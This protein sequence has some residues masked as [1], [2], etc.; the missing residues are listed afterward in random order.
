MLV[1]QRSTFQQHDHVLSEE[2]SAIETE[3]GSLSTSLIS[4]LDELH[5]VGIGYC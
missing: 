2:A 1:G 3:M 5:V 4:M